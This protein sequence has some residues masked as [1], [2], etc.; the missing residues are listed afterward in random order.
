MFPLVAKE[1]HPEKNGELTPEKVT[2]KSG[3]KVWW[4][5]P[6]DHSY[7]ASVHSRAGSN[8]GCPYCAGQKSLNLDLWKQ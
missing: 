2:S 5:C 3:K 1:W 4:I 7:E 6:K 8:S